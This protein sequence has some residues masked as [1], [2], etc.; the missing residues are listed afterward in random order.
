MDNFLTNWFGIAI[1]ILIVWS[2]VNAWASLK[3]GRVARGIARERRSFKRWQ[4]LVE[5]RDIHQRKWN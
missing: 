4:R 5:L 2:I 1:L 3:L